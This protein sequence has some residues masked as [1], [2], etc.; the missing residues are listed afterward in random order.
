M[1]TIMNGS[2]TMSNANVT[3]VAVSCMTR[4]YTVGGN[5]VGTTGPLVLKNNGGDQI[6][7]NAAGA[8][9]FAT[10]V[11][12]GNT[13]A[14]TVVTPP[15]GQTCVVG[16]GTGTVANGN[17]SGVSVTC[18]TPVGNQGILCDGKYCAL[19]TEECC[20]TNNTTYSCVSKCTGGN[21]APVK[22]DSAAD[23]DPGLVCCGSLNG[24]IVNNIF[25]SGPAQC[26]APKAYFC[27]PMVANPCP[28]GG[29]CTAT[30]VPPGYYRC[31]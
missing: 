30:D 10:A 6:T 26:A 29:T 3:N 9:V 19:G 1:C 14:V 24:T 25:C 28:N 12:S 4:S 16:N 18:S 13:Y 23:C 27:D 7:V 22:C 8:F 2:G 31:Y 15:S 21:T 5:A 17:V 20:V 11:A